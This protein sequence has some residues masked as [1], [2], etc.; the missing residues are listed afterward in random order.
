MKAL[1]ITLAFVTGI[2]FSSFSQEARSAQDEATA[3]M[4]EITKEITLTEQEHTLLYRQVYTQH[5]NMRR[6]D[7]MPGT[8]KEKAEMAAQ[9]SVRYHDGVK[10]I[11]GEER[12]A[13]FVTVTKAEEVK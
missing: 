5:D 2:C 10:N 1:I 8:D 9:Q 13:K 3:T 6:L 12:Y 4:Q 7:K 11:L